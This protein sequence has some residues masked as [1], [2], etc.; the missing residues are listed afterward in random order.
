MPNLTTTKIKDL[1]EFVIRYCNLNNIPI[2]NLKLQKLLYYIQAWHLVYFDK[3]PLFSNQPEAWVNGP[4]YR[5]IYN[6]YKPYSYLDIRLGFEVSNKES[7]QKALDKLA[8]TEDQE[9]YM[10]SVLDHFSNKTP[11]ELVLRTHRDAPW[12]EAR[13]GLGL[14]DYTDEI[15]TYDLMYNYYSSLKVKKDE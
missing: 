12:N 1:A 8:L 11:D 4:V 15:I 9:K 3:H 6:D 10:Q 2:S 14:L 13:K 5:E 7:Y